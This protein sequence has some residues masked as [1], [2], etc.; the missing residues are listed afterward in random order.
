MPSGM[1][2]L[3]LFFQSVISLQSVV[4]VGLVAHRKGQ[5]CIMGVFLPLQNDVLLYWVDCSFNVARDN[6]FTVFTFEYI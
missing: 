4:A 5:L 1:L 6:H 2:L 3:I